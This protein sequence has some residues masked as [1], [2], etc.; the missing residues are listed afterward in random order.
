MVLL[1]IAVFMLT[2]RTRALESRQR[3]TF[4]LVIPL[5]VGWGTGCFRTLCRI[6]TLGFKEPLV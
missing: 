6:W 4:N 3:K 2:L 5:C 1:H